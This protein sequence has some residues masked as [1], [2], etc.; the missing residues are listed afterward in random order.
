VRRGLTLLL[1]CAV[2]AACGGGSGDEEAA[3]GLSDLTSVD[4]LRER[5]NEDRGQARLLLLLSPT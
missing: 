3:R 2:V 4:Q 1:L 5:F